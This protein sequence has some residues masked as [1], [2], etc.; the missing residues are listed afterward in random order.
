MKIIELDRMMSIYGD[1]KL[2]V[3]RN[4]LLK[5][6]P[7]ICPKCNGHGCTSEQYNAYPSGL[8]DSGWVQDIRSRDVK[9]TVCNGE[10]YTPKLLRAIIKTEV[11]GYA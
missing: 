11:T 3:I 5:N 2:S 7:H 8:P 1:V 6:T 9:C 4:N 10:G